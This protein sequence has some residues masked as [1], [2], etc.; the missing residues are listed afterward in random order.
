MIDSKQQAYLD[1]LDIGVWCLRESP[2]VEIPGSELETGLKL[3][4]GGGGI[5]LVCAQ[6]SHSASRL[7]NDISRALGSVPVWAWPD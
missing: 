5:L 7:A 2:T 1:A 6:D 3:G 4:P